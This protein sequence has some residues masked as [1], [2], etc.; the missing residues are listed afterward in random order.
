MARVRVYDRSLAGVDYVLKG[1]DL[2]GANFHEFSK[3]K[4]AERLTLSESFIRVID[5]TRGERRGRQH[6]AEGSKSPSV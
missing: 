6:R 1:F 4:G 5:R 2:I 3:F